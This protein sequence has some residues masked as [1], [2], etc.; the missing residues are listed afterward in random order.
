MARAAFRRYAQRQRPESP[1]GSNCPTSLAPG[2]AHLVTH[3]HARK[4]QARGWVLA[5]GGEA[6][7][8]C[9]RLVQLRCQQR[10]AFGRRAMPPQNRSTP[11]RFMGNAHVSSRPDKAK[12][13]SLPAGWRRVLQRGCEQM[14]HAARSHMLL[15]APQAPALVKY[16][17]EFDIPVKHDDPGLAVTVARH[18]ETTLDVEEDECITRFLSSVS[19]LRARLS[20]PSPANV[21]A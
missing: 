13:G 14:H 20:G 10:R 6:S 8:A 9:V 7:R 4:N 2:C 15:S 1:G 17:K 16:C 18:F 19:R 11:R 12:G 5:A 3:G 21:R